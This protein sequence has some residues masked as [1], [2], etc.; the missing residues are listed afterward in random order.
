PGDVF[1]EIAFFQAEGRTARVAAIEESVLLV[2][3]HRDFRELLDRSAEMTRRMLTLLATRLKN[4]IAHFDDT[5]SLDVPQRLARK[6]LLLA[7]HYGSADQGGTRLTL[8]LSQSDLGELV[9]A[10]RQSVNRLLR[11]WHDA[12]ILE[13]DDGQIVVRDLEGL[14]RIAG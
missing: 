14:R 9:D 12:K 13:T 5:T 3:D 8:K 2:I 7:K 1:G 4:T 10:T 6:L 11:A